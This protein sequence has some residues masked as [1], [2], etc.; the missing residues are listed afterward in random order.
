MQCTQNT[1]TTTVTPATTLRDAAS[2]LARHGWVQ[3]C[4]YDYTAT[5]FTPAAC[6][7]GAIGIVCYGGPVDAPAQHFE[8]PG[9]AQ[10][11]AA[12][13]FLDLYL[14]NRYGSTVAPTSYDF[15][16]AKGRTAD[17]VIGVLNAAAD[18]WDR[19]YGGA[20]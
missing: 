9:W 1:V 20:A 8:A 14:F 15:N 5:V 6:V 4:Y 17:E 3:G 7:V 18:E 19:T 16:D 2:Y 11:E 10:F 12:L 13:A